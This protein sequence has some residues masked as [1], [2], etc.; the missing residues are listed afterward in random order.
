VYDDMARAGAAR[1]RHRERARTKAHLDIRYVGQEFALSVPVSVEQL[2]HGDRESIRA[3]FDSL[4]EQRYAHG[5]PDEPV[6]IINVRVAVLGKRPPLELP[7]C[8]V[9][10]PVAAARRRRVYLADRA[11]PLECPVY[12]RDALGASARIDGPALVQEHGTTTVLFAGD[13]CTVADTGELVVTVG[14]R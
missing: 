1:L 12:R 5:S 6:E 8:P 2:R 10:G 13:R 11:R 14:S 7:R 9:A 3:L 4:Y